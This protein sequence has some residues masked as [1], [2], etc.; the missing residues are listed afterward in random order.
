M[1]ISIKDLDGVAAAMNRGNYAAIATARDALPAL[2]AI[3]KAALAWSEAHGDSYARS[4]AGAHQ[5]RCQATD[6]ALDRALKQVR[7]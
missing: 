6:L 7:P 4:D 2:L 1:K 3:A 5:A